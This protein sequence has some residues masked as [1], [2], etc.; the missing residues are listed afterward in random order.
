[1]LLHLLTIYSL[2]YPSTSCFLITLPVA[3]ALN[4]LVPHIIL[5]HLRRSFTPPLQ[6]RTN[7][8]GLFPGGT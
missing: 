4:T 2:F 3:G 1:M 5:R 8:A 7:Y 6:T